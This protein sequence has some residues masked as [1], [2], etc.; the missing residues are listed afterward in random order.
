MNDLT[1]TLGMVGGTE[2]EGLPAAVTAAVPPPVDQQEQTNKP[3]KNKVKTEEDKKPE[4]GVSFKGSEAAEF[5]RSSTK[6]INLNKNKSAGEYREYKFENRKEPFN[7]E[8]IISIPY[9]DENGDGIVD[10]KNIDELTLDAYWYDEE[11][12]EWKILSDMLIFPKE[13]IVTVKTNHFTVFGVAGA[14]RT[15]DTS[16]QPED[17]GGDTGTGDSGNGGSGNGGSCFIATAAFGSPVAGEVIA[18][19][20]LR[21]KYL[22]KSKIGKRFVNFYYCFSPPAADFIKNRP[23]LKSAIRYL[24]KFLAILLKIMLKYP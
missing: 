14:E 22:L 6:E 20:E 11:A 15:N 7:K 10:D 9:T 12:G 23:A 16:S 1:S 18:L 5:G 17:S 24:L 8:M 3:P 19:K 13:N 2:A 4:I 21:D